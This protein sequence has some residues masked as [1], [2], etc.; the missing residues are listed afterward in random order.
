MIIEH[1]QHQ[2]RKQYVEWPEQKKQRKRHIHSASFCVQ[3]NL[4]GARKYRSN[5]RLSEQKKFYDMIKSKKLKMHIKQY[6]LTCAVFLLIIKKYSEMT[7][8]IF[9]AAKCNL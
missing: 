8:V 5:V 6:F 9:I 1:R 7:N 2:H 4:H 3:L